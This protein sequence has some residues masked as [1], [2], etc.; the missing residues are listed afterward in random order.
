MSAQ[1]V[2]C[3]RG[4]NS[5]DMHAI[6]SIRL[7][8]GE[9]GIRVISPSALYEYFAMDGNPYVLDFIPMTRY[10]IKKA[11]QWMQSNHLV[12]RSGNLYAMTL[13]ELDYPLFPNIHGVVQK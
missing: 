2:S 13:L 11:L 4:L 10:R 8:V 1:I 7:A 3:P 5:F 9:G 6:N 12:Q